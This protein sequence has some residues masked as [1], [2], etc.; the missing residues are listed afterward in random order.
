MIEQFH[1]RSVTRALLMLTLSFLFALCSWN[2][3]VH[4]FFLSFPRLTAEVCPSSAYSGTWTQSCIID[5][6]CY[7]IIGVLFTAIKNS[8]SP[9]VC[10]D[11]STLIVATCSFVSCSSTLIEES[12]GGIEFSGLKQVTI[13]YCCAFDCHAYSSGGFIEGWT[14]ID[15]S[16]LTIDGVSAA[17]CVAR[18]YYGGGICFVSLNSKSDGPPINIIDANFTGC[19]STSHGCAIMIH[20][21]NAALRRVITSANSG[22]SGISMYWKSFVMEVRDSIFVNA[23]NQY[24]ICITRSG[25]TVDIEN[26]LF[27]NILGPSLNIATG[28][29]RVRNS[30]FSA[31]SFPSSS[32]VLD[33]GGNYYG[34]TISINPE[35]GCPRNWS[36]QP[37]IPAPLCLTQSPFPILTQTSSACSSSAFQASEIAVS[38]ELKWSIALRATASE[39]ESSKPTE[40]SSFVFSEGWNSSGMVKNSIP[41]ILSSTVL[42]YSGRADPSDS[43]QL[44]KSF[45]TSITFPF[46]LS[47]SFSM[48]AFL[49]VSL[50]PHDT[51]AFFINVTLENDSMA[52]EEPDLCSSSVSLHSRGFDSFVSGLSASFGETIVPSGSAVLFT[53]PLFENTDL[54]PS[55]VRW[56]TTGESGIESGSGSGSGIRELGKA[57]TSLTIIFGIIGATLLLIAIAVTVIVIY[58]CRSRMKFSEEEEMSVQTSFPTDFNAIFAEYEDGFATYLNAM[59]FL[60]TTTMAADEPSTVMMHDS[61]AAPTLQWFD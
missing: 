53:I 60:E 26:C 52:F 34:I 32:N 10:K 37:D 58:R 30:G 41:I 21:E 8:A 13:R 11:Q 50:I 61:D 1:A 15:P 38:R 4:P 35:S 54:F 3:L 19:S 31:F 14:M 36:I 47:L 12:S 9:L 33:D 7:K 45:T 42:Q 44:S 6:A 23:S 51:S 55:D 22:S 59:T 43:L 5:I 48:S 29:I 18:K 56:P 27:S 40:G 25:P 57:G 46:S 20:T 39:L 2:D 49:I 16:R 28:T 24:S 17:S